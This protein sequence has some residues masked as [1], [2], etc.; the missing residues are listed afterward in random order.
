MA[1]LM[2]FSQDKKIRPDQALDL[3]AQQNESGGGGQQQMDVGGQ[4][5]QIHLPNGQ[6]MGARTPSLGHMAMMSGQANPGAGNQFTSP[7]MANMGLPMQHQ[8]IP[9]GPGQMNGSPH[10]PN[11]VIPNPGLNAPMMQQPGSHTPSPRQTN[12]AAPPMVPQHSQQGTTS[13]GASANTSPQVSN[14]RR[15]S[16]VKVEEEGAS[17]SQEGG[18]AGAMQQPGGGRVKPS[19]RMGKKGKPGG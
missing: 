14:K 5:P 13:S 8:Q 10:I 3:W 17:A 1:E 7:A 18:G 12:M 2:Q 16:T 6:P 11:H 9:N 15:R 19:P 4:N